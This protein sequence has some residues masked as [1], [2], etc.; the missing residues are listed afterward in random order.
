LASSTVEF[1]MPCKL[2]KQMQ[3]R[4]VKSREY[5]SP[6]LLLRSPSEDSSP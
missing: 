1:R 6:A 3:G 5:D 2:M 4:T